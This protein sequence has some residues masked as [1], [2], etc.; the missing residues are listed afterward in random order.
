MLMLSIA[1]DLTNL[2][3]SKVPNLVLASGYDFTD[4]REVCGP[5]PLEHVEA[6]RRE[7]QENDTVKVKQR[8]RNGKTSTTLSPQLTSPLD[9]DPAL[10]IPGTKYGNSS[11]HL[12]G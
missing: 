9:F 6:S 1:I 5:G 7:W 12:P 10:I 2:R 11:F 8:K 4:L 3:Y